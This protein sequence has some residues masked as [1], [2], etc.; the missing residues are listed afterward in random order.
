MPAKC[1][2]CGVETKVEEAFYQVISKYSSVIT[3]RCPRC[4]H[5]ARHTAYKRFLTSYLILGIGAAIIVIINPEYQFGWLIL[6]FLLYYVF[7]VLTALPHELGHAIAAKAVGFRVFQVTIGFGRAI[8]KCRLWGFNF[9][10]NSMPLGGF[11]FSVSR[12]VHW[13]RSKRC[14]MIL[15]GPLTNI[16]AAIAVLYLFPLGENDF[17]VFSGVRVKSA[18]VIANAISAAFS[19]WPKR[20]DS[21]YGRVANDGLLFWKTLFLKKQE[22]ETRPA[23]YYLYEGGELLSAKKPEAAKR[24]L[25]QGLTLFPD[26]VHL[27]FALASAFLKMNKLPESR[28]IN[29]RLVNRPNVGTYYRTLFA[30][31]LAYVDVLI[32]EKQLIEEADKYSKEALENMP[33]VSY[34][35]GTRG[36]VLVELGK[37]EEGIS[38]LKEAIDLGENN[39]SKALNAC[40]VALAEKKRGNL[41]ES[42][43]YAETAR[44]LDADCVL[45]E[46][47]K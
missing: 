13:Y 20:F 25:E 46:R 21:A 38:L 15:A 44:S 7:G 45:L 12:K 40:H 33:Y 28:E 29:V 5:K 18:F 1:D 31:N 24:L 27:S 9:V 17:D 36:C 22:I 43:K 11:C 39:E 23:S 14:L 2:I 30:N 16:L 32:G 34:F 10:V 41:V 42:Q 3:R 19:L 4:W 8:F 47:L 35:K 37:I 26:N 6:N